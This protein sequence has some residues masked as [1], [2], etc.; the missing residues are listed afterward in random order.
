MG[1]KYEDDE[2]TLTMAEI[3]EILVEAYGDSEYD[4]QAGCYGGNG[5]WLSIDNILG[6]LSAGC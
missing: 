2:R 6:E 1:M 3:E 5:A 4:R